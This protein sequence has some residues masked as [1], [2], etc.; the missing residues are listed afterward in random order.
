VKKPA[1]ARSTDHAELLF[2]VRKGTR[3][4]E[5]VARAAVARMPM[6]VSGHRVKVALTLFLL[7][8]VAE[9]VVARAIREGKNTPG[10]IADILGAESR[11][12]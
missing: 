6:T 10:V 7:H 12:K 2:P 9:Y 4:S 3:S 8:E 5:E 11:R 1:S